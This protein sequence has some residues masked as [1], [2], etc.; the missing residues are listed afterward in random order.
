MTL[1]V[2]S[3]DKKCRVLLVGG[4]ARTR[5]TTHQWD[6]TLLPSFGV[7]RLPEGVFAPVP[8]R[9][10]SRVFELLGGELWTLVKVSSG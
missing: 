1:W 6:Y 9:R 2:S 7:G 10:A 5:P 3:V 8:A 4:R